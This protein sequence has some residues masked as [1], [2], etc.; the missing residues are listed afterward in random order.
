M[1]EAYGGDQGSDRALIGAI[2]RNSKKSEMDDSEF[3]RDRVCEFGEFGEDENLSNLV[4]KV[5]GD[6]FDLCCMTVKPENVARILPDR[7]THIKFFPR[8]SSRIIV[9]GNKLGDVG[10]WN[11]DHR[12]DGGTEDGIYMY[13]AHSG[14]VSGI[15]IHKHCLSKVYTS[16]NDGFIRSM[17]AEKEVFDLIYSSKYSICSLS[18]RSNDAKCLYFGDASGLLNIW[19]ERMGKCSTRKFLHVGRIN[20]IDFNSDNPYTLATS[21][22]D[23]N[24]CVWDLR[25]IDTIKPETLNTISHKESVHSAYFSPSG[26]CLV[27]SCFDNKVG[28]HSG[29]NFEETSMIRH[30]NQAGIWFAPFR[31]I[32]GWD[33][34]HIF[35]GSTKIGRGVDVISPSQRRTIFT[36]QSPHVTAIPCTFDAYPYNVGMLAGAIS[37]VQVYLWTMSCGI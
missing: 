32:W 21:S 18:Q 2:L 36:L 22:S 20:S 4:K 19:D 37:R 14:S 7:I 16:C 24:V 30:K 26:K 23:G 6:S 27:S 35:I 3:G 12:R 9:A 33:D 29:I 10:F 28:I 8:S 15:S 5:E 17:D 11:L 13:H 1:S 25:S 34:S 31:A